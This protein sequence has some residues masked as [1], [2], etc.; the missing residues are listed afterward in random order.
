MS[1]RTVGG[2]LIA[3]LMTSSIV[4]ADDG[5]ARTSANAR[6]VAP[7]WTF[8][9]IGA[10][11]GVGLWAGFSAFDESINSERKIWTSAIVGAAAGGLLGYFVDRQRAK[12]PAAPARNPSIAMSTHDQRSLVSAAGQLGSGQLKGWLVEE[13]ARLPL[14]GSSEVS[15]IK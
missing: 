7:V 12:S 5:R 1:T 3:L 15:S 2:A 14:A 8:V 4:L 13:R 6:S 9:G 10:G 11:F